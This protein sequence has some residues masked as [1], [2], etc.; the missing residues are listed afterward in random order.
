MSLLLDNEED[1]NIV[2]SVYSILDF[3][4]S[5]ARSDPTHENVK[6]MEGSKMLMSLAVKHTA[7][8]ECESS[9][10]F[11]IKLTTTSEK[12]KG[13]PE[14]EKALHQIIPPQLR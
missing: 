7:I 5:I 2:E 12:Y 6:V 13:K 14:V 8:Y 9:Y 11:L 4:I 1:E 3:F 10:Q